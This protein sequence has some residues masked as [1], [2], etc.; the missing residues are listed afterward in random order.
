MKRVIY[1]GSDLLLGVFDSLL[2]AGLMPEHCYVSDDNSAKALIKA[3]QSLR[4]PVHRYKPES[5]RLA[6][7]IADGINLF[8]CAEYPWRIPL[9]ETLTWGVN[10]HASLLPHCAGQTPL[11]YI[12]EKAGHG[13]GITCHRLTNILDA[14]P[15]LDARSIK[16]D[17]SD[18]LNTLITK[19]KLTV[20]AFAR[21]IFADFEQLYDAATGTN[22]LF[23]YPPYPAN[24]RV[25][26]V[27]QTVSE[28][29]K[30]IR[31][32][33]C[34]GIIIT[35]NERLYSAVGAKAIHYDHDMPPGTVV[36]DDPHLLSLTLSDGIFTIPKQGIVSL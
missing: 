25:F 24:K 10:F 11:P 15:I 33:G 26:N 2:E 1:F 36:C 23:Y 32:Y 29:E 19:L 6:R 5:G 20:P 9:P 17:I 3:C 28:A 4:I 13:A 8:V 22:D 21:D 30:Q 18:D 27:R 35:L 34:Y 16:F 7:Q 14:G 31:I 12:V